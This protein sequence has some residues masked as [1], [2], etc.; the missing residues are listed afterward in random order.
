MGR[1][2]FLIAGHLCMA[3]AFVGIFVPIL[4]TVPFILLAAYCYS[5]G[6][7]KFYNWLVKHPKFGPS[8]IEWRDHRIVRPRAKIASVITIAI[9]LS[10]PIFVVDLPLWQKVTVAVIGV[11]VM[12]F[13]ISCPSE[14]PKEDP[15]AQ[16]SMAPD[17]CP[18]P[19]LADTNQSSLTHSA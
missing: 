6:S 11:S 3:L 4:P 2:I 9:S 18:D 16:D 12:I 5:R 15:E 1:I 17:Q 19:D 8:V 7:T 14:K 10:I 13:L